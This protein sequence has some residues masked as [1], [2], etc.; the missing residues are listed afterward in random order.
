[1]VSIANGAASLQDPCLADSII[2]AGFECQ[3]SECRMQ[4]TC[5]LT[6]VDDAGVVSYVIDFAGN[7]SGGNGWEAVVHS[8]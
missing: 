2:A 8:F 1:M 4:L 3:Q 5:Y 6:V 7:I